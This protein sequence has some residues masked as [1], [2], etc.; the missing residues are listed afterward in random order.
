VDAVDTTGAGDCFTAA[1]TVARLRGQDIPQALRYATA[2]A[3]LC[4][5]RKGAMRSMPSGVEV[6]KFLSDWPEEASRQS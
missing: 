1:F 3:A 5:T 6:E 4:V 2:A